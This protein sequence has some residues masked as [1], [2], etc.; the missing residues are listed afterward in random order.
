MLSAWIKSRDRNFYEIEYSCKYG[1]EISKSRKY[2]HDKFNPDFFIKI[3]KNST[4]YYLVIEIKDDGD[5]SEENKA[6]Y[7]YAIQHFNELNSRMENEGKNEKY[8][9]HFL[10]PN[11]YDTFFQHLKDG[12]VLDG[13]DRFRCELENLLSEEM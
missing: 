5:Y 13:Q 6:K 7:R 10:S 1:S 9:F 12:S 4:E 8:I 2:Y 3:D 11:S